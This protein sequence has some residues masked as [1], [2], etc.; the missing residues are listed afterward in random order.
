MCN[1]N[2][3]QYS[4]SYLSHLLSVGDILSLGDSLLLDLLPETLR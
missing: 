1:I 2:C 4:N 3:D